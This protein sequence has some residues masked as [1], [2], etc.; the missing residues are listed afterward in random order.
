[1]IVRWT[2]GRRM[3]APAIAAAILAVLVAVAN[4]NPILPYA[5]AGAGGQNAGGGSGNGNGGN[6]GGGNPRAGENNGHNGGSDHS[7]SEDGDKDG[8]GP[9]YSAGADAVERDGG[10]RFV[11]GEV[12]VANLSGDA[13]EDVRQLGFVVLGEQQLPS[14]G[15][16][17]TRLRV[18]Q[19]MTTPAAQTLLAARF[20]TML[21]DVNAVYRPQGELVLPPP[22][23][24]AKLIGWGH[25][26]DT[27]GRGIRI[28][29]LDT[30][31]D[32]IETG[33]RGAH[34]E[35]RS[36][37]SSD[38]KPAPTE[39]GT[40]IAEILV[41]QQDGTSGHGLLPSAELTVANVFAADTAGAPYADVMALLG[42][43]DWLA[44]SG[45]PVINMSFSGDA[46][47]LMTLALQRATVGRAIVV[48]A[49]G[50]D[51]R[52]APPSFPAAVPGV[53]G[54]TAVDSR[55]QP[56]DDANN[57]DY[58]DFAAPGVRIW[59]PSRG[60]GGSYNTGTSFAAPFVAA[61]VAAL[62]AEGAP[63]DPD[64]IS[65]SLA[66]SAIDLGAPGKDPIFGWGLIQVANPCSQP[67]Q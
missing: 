34:I 57:G 41:G 32:T 26:P 14:L 39:H 64:R 49:V 7:A 11:P 61:A 3:A 27:C 53:I 46:N 52:A 17:V 38:A 24:T 45:A 63:R 51:G 30:A 37:L 54:V 29:M 50:N 58:V 20:P 15:L 9:E 5:L 21:V 33:L 48:A 65:Q 62:L 18:P 13:E 1:M 2:H 59:T 31:V 47:S 35:Q 56:Y 60:P 42:G 8:M 16:T 66:E 25:T 12:V 36:F 10:D 28:A 44:S 22:D 19:R 4:P 6:H 67:T 40:A 43:L 55:S 23:Y